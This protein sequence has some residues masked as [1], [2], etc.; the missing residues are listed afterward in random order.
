[1]EQNE[2]SAIGRR[3]KE[4]RKKAGFSQEGL[5]EFMNFDSNN[6][7]RIERGVATPKIET[8]LGIVNAL[9]ITPNDILLESFNAPAALLDAEIARLISDMSTAERAKVIEYIE[10][11]N[12]QRGDQ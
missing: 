2:R 11:I 10:F 6:L 9:E 4:Y 5:A 7:S 3:I 1:M 8:L 12:Y